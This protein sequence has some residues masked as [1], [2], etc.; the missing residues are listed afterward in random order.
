MLLFSMHIGYDYEGTRWS[1]VMNRNQT[2]ARPPV[3]LANYL[4]TSVRASP[5]SE[6]PSK[7]A[8]CD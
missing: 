2:F 1:K 4:E 8:N 5:A 7:W 3:K 6:H